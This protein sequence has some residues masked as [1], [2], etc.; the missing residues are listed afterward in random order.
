MGSLRG[1]RAPQGKT[2]ISAAVVQKIAG[3][4][5]REIAGVYAMDAGMSRAFG[6]FRGRVEHPRMYGTTPPGTGGKVSTRPISVRVT[7]G[8]GTLSFVSQSWARTRTRH[9]VWLSRAEIR[10][11]TV[12]DARSTAQRQ[13]T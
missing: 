10:E 9:P 13:R 11:R 4:A 3:I 5:A 12:L 6:A 8:P 2:T 1:D 7:V